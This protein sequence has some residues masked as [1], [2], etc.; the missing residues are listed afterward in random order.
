MSADG[1]I[2]RAAEIP[3]A[4][5]PPMA[6]PWTIYLIV[7]VL[8]GLLRLPLAV[9][10]YAAGYL[11]GDTTL[12]NVDGIGYVRKAAGVQESFGDLNWLY[13]GLNALVFRL[14]GGEQ[15][16]YL[17]MSLLNVLMA[18]ALPL[19][20]W[21]AFRALVPESVHRDRARLIAIVALAFWPTSIW[22]STQNM[23]DT[24]LALLICAFTSAAVTVLERGSRAYAALATLVVT[25]WLILSL[26]VYAVAILGGAFIITVLL[27]WRRFPVLLLVGALVAIGAVLGPLRGTIETV[28]RPENRFFFDPEVV[29]AINAQRLGESEDFLQINSTLPAIARDALRAPLNPFP[30]LYWRNGYDGLL[31]LRTVAVALTFGGFLVWLVRWRSPHRPFF[32]SALLL[33]WVFFSVGRSYS[34]PRQIYSTIEP[35]MVIAAAVALSETG[36]ARFWARSAIGGTLGLLLLLVYTSLNDYAALAQSGR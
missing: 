20:A 36:R 6:S 14:G 28:L 3:G 12:I 9:Y 31:M 22:I 27:Q 19:A 16:L 10:N 4:G 35:A 25:A 11:G 13:E 21:P 5:S 26:R 18:M 8:G 7:A 32:V 17:Q 15:W 1:A 29:N 2:V 30:S 24:M 34:G 23:K 33:S